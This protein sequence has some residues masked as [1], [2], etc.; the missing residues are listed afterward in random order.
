MSLA[1]A[2]QATPVVALLRREPDG[3]SGFVDAQI[4]DHSKGKWNSLVREVAPAITK[5]F[6]PESV[7]PDR[8]SGRGRGSDTV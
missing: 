8:R 7:P 5:E 3:S 6:I 4:R 2:T 1:L